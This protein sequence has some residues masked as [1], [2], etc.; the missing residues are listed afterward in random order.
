M[1]PPASRVT[2]LPAAGCPRPPSTAWETGLHRRSVTH[3]ESPSQQG[4]GARF[5]P[6][7]LVSCMCPHG[8][9]GS[10]PQSCTP[11]LCI[12]SRPMSTTTPSICQCPRESSTGSPQDSEGNRRQWATGAVRGMETGQ[13]L[14]SPG[15]QGGGCIVP[16]SQTS[17]L[18][19][20]RLR[21]WADLSGSHSWSDR[22]WIGTVAWAGPTGCW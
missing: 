6:R 4:S 1:R 22:A 13:G 16:I 8:G 2:A 9:T 5:E 3:P 12:L 19:P 21:L 7:A 10:A 20:K 11:A 15:D 17:K 14:T 18:Q